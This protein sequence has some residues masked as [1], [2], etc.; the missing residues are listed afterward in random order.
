MRKFSLLL[1][2]FICQLILLILLFPNWFAE[3]VQQ[4]L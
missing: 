1:T 3:K 4:L 2:M